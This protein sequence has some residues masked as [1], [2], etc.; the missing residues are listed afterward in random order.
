MK[1]KFEKLKEISVS[2]L[3]KCIFW[4][5]L[6]V[7][8][9][10]AVAFEDRLQYSFNNFGK[11]E[12]HDVKTYFLD[13]GQ[14]SSTVII[15][16][17]DKVM[18]VDTGSVDSEET[19]MEQVDVIFR[20][21]NIDKVD[22]L[23]LSHSDADHIGGTVAL[24]KKYQVD[25]VV[26]PNAK[27]TSEFETIEDALT[28]STETYKN[29]ID[30]IYSEPNCEVSTTKNESWQEGEACVKIYAPHET[31]YSDTNSYSSIVYIEYDE[32]SFLLMGDAV[33][34]R[35]SEFI[36]DLEDDLDVTFL[37]VAH[38]GSKTSTTQEFLGKVH[39]TYAIV[40]AEDDVYPTS[41]VVER[42]EDADVEQIYCT[43]DR[44]MI[45]V[46]VSKDGNFE[47]HSMGKRFELPALLCCFALLLF[48]FMKI[49]EDS[50]AGKTIKFRK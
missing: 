49:I 7:I 36:S 40:S 24:L 8:C 33:G 42:L 14:A 48:L 32:Q 15:F 28:V 39:P 43:R 44:G 37:L 3:I 25:K 23:I 19:F 5:I 22:E 13:V 30:A 6:V 50:F 18:I 2:S 1:K 34:V 16:P 21:N 29:V 31:S 47:V 11:I 17:N 4:A 10:L 46:G 35:E 38:H 26:R 41:E 45:G 12:K 27:S 20:A 9:I